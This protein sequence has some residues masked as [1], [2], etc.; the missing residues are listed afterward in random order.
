MPR[1]FFVCYVF[2]TIELAFKQDYLCPADNG[3]ATQ[4]I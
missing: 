1:P 2:T 3:A 4:Y